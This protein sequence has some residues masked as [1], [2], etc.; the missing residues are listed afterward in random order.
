MLFTSHTFRAA[1]PAPWHPDPASSASRPHPLVA[2]RRTESCA[3][4]KMKMKQC[5][6][7]VHAFFG[8][9][10]NPSDATVQVSN[11]LRLLFPTQLRDI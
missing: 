5:L 3:R 7:A 1:P 11:D 2:R 9:R 10:S 6:A 8:E 4:V